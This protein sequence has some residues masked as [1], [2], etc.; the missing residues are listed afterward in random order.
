V[1]IY[2]SKEREIEGKHR[3][4]MNIREATSIE[5]EQ[6]R[7]VHLSAFNESENTV[8]AQLITKLLI[9]TDAPVLSL[10]AEDQNAIVGN[11][12]FSTVEIEGYRNVTAFILAPL[13]VLPEF[14]KRGIG[15]S[16]IV[17]GLSI[18]KE[19]GIDLVFVYGNPAFYS[20]SGFKSAY[21]PQPYRRRGSGGTCFAGVCGQDDHSQAPRDG[22]MASRETGA[23]RPGFT[24]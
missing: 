5:H 16:L 10:V 17:N 1:E 23:P 2:R 20:R 13:A 19:R 3:G 14:Q 18:L 21:N 11:I 8:I 12:I 6:I 15:T 24:G 22:F 4:F 9:A 7:K